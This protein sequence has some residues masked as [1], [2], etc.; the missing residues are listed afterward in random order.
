MLK[1]FV[2]DNGQVI[3][4][5]ETFA[6]MVTNYYWHVL[7]KDRNKAYYALKYGVSMDNNELYKLKV[8]MEKYIA[9]ANKW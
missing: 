6:G 4:K 5:V 9:V 7:G 8:F 3:S 2:D 1:L